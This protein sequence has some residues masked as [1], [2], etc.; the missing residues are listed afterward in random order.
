MAGDNGK[1]ALGKRFRGERKRLGMTSAQV[2]VACSVTEA[3]VFNW[4]AGKVNMPLAA[5][6]CLWEQGFDPEAIIPGEAGKMQSLP[7]R[8]G[9]KR[10]P[11][12]VPAHILARHRVDVMRAFVFHSPARAADLLAEGEV[13]LM[14]AFW[15]DTSFPEDIDAICLL[16]WRARKAEF[17]CRVK[18]TGGKK[19]SLQLGKE[20]ICTSNRQI[21]AACSFVG[22]FVCRLGNKPAE[23]ASGP[24]HES[25]FAMLKRELD[26]QRSR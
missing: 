10:R 8:I 9:E 6:S 4:E 17:V 25:V 2:A 15:E 7:S 24:S 3:T 22:R 12:Q 23:K 13:C 20:R 19:V 26:K 11:H 21:E 18:T 5:L 16:A 1:K 14:E